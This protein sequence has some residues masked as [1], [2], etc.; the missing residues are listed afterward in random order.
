MSK[1]S[2]K[3]SKSKK[4]LKQTRPASQ[5]IASGKQGSS[6]PAPEVSVSAEPQFDSVKSITSAAA[7]KLKKLVPLKS[8]KH[9][10]P[11]KEV[12][13][14]SKQPEKLQ[15][16]KLQV[17]E[18]ATGLSS[19]L[20]AAK[21]FLLQELVFFERDREK[22]EKLKTA[23]WKFFKVSSISLLAVVALASI[24]IIVD[25]YADQRVLPNTSIGGIQLGFVPFKTAKQT[26]MVELDKYQKIPLTFT[27]EKETASFTPEELGIKFPLD[28]N[29]GA[30]PV[31]AFNKNTIANLATSLIKKTDKDFIY[32][33][34]REKLQSKLETEFK[35]AEKRAKN[36]HFVA[37]KKDFLIEKEVAGARISTSDLE[38]QLAAN[39]NNLQKNNIS[40]HLESEYPSITAAQLEQQKERLIALFQ[41]PV[42]I[43][44]E[45]KKLT[46]KLADHLDSVGF[47]SSGANKDLQPYVSS[48]L[49]TY[50]D[51]NILKKIEIP[52]SPVNITQDESGKIIIEGK[53]E[54]GRAVQKEKLLADITNAVNANVKE[55]SI[56][57]VTDKAPV[58]IADSLKD[59]GIK[60]LLATGH[61]AYYGSPANRM[62]NITLGLSK[63]NGVLLKPGE[64]FSFNKYMGDVDGK[65]GYLPEK[66]IK[67]NKIELEMGGGLCQVSTTAYRAA[68]L[69]GL[70]ITE[71]APHS[72]KVSYYSQS[73]GNGLDATVYTGSHD[74]KFINDTPG[75]LLIQSYNEG[76]D[77]YFKFYG[78]GDG[79]TVVM[80]GPYGSGLNYRWT[81]ILTKADQTVVKETI[82][83]NY[84]PL[85]PP[86][87]ING[88]SA[89]GKP[90]TVALATKPATVPNP[91]TKP[92]T[93]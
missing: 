81:R 47:K 87:Q 35:L 27:Y 48:Y 6:A 44:Y 29:T 85:P 26:L 80:D 42:T 58:T 37:D 64:E 13:A 36:A 73:M 32:T 50:L 89:G 76:S 52:T 3:S 43:A 75:Y 86:D 53:A 88:T 92:V 77:A 91:V 33:I 8:K 9:E 67:Q 55:V 79:R 61:S 1:K 34:D 12:S 65:N 46:F 14:K 82:I 78:T 51:E 59:L 63:Y 25:I 16:E 83:S 72:W 28:K 41:K 31:Y 24:I 49:L 62:H 84:K 18:P 60:E 69:A 45:N 66:V 68:L 5:K 93:Q 38:K 30:V 74:F 15:L 2:K 20:H 71:R 54:D 40:L 4:T 21:D 39:L 17:I 10:A 57:V 70:P 23:A 22:F 56:P 90:K 7:K 11:L 19:H